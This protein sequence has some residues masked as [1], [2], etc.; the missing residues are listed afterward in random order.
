LR[1]NFSK[2]ARTGSSSKRL[3]TTEACPPFKVVVWATMLLISPVVYTGPSELSYLV[4]M[5]HGTW[6]GKEG[7]VSI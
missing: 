3:I 6:V 4:R 7:V 5:L 1:L 2:E